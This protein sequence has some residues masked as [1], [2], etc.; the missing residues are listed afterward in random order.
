MSPYLTSITGLLLFWT[1]IG[2]G[3]NTLP[4]F[5]VEVQTP[6]CA[7]AMDGALVLTV[8]E[9]AF[10][11]T[12]RW[13]QQSN[14]Q[15]IDQGTITTP[16]VSVMTPNT[17]SAGAYVLQLIDSNGFIYEDT[18]PI[19]NPTPITITS[20]TI[21]DATCANDCNGQIDLAFTG[22]TGE[23]TINWLD[24]DN[25]HEFNRTELCGGDYFF[26][27][28]DENGCTQKG[29]IPI[30]APPPIV[31]AA[32]VQS[33][34][35]DQATNGRIQLDI[36]GGT[37]E[38]QLNW[39]DGSTSPLRENLASATYPLTVTDANDC[40]VSEVY[41]LPQGP[42]LLPNVRY[43]SGCGDGNILVSCAPIHGHAPY[44]YEWSTGSTNAALGG[45]Y[46]GNYSLSLTDANGCIA[47]TSFE[48]PYVVP[49]NVSTLPT[50]V[51]CAGAADGAINLVILG[52]TPP[53]QVNWD[54][55]M[56]GQN[57]SAL[58][59]GDY[60]YNVTAQGCGRS[61][62]LQLTEPQALQAEVV[63]TNPLGSTLSGQAIVSGGTTPYTIEW[64][65][66]GNGPVASN[67]LVNQTYAVSVTDANNC[68]FTTD[69]SAQLTS[70][71]ESSSD[72]LALF[73]NPTRGPLQLVSS[74]HWTAATWLHP[75]G[76]VLRT[77]S[78]NDL[79]FLNIS[80]W[81]AGTYFL[82]LA[83]EQQTVLRQVVKL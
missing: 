45:M 4:V 77:G 69:V 17:L 26:R 72:Q 52:G 80:T 20:F 46:A 31:V 76:R 16:G 57:I 67:L 5:A 56:T 13:E 41:E 8:T 28:F 73:P 9:G 71:Y 50:P 75:T 63:F 51:S 55:G 58:T 3:Q 82:R 38:H 65:N 22:G 14:D 42:A 2:Y 53:F 40:L 32:D 25:N 43:Q 18:F 61:G 6:S 30:L 7:Q 54:N 59:G 66:G 60:V 39:A 10:P 33:P 49:I 1:V 64:S 79:A 12:Y 36:S 74:L 81:P 47:N 29:S 70:L 19:T 44:Q 83:N 62:I 24:D 35:C 34:T 78:A 21:S 27:V 23:L 15:L 48:I 11:I 37:G 68:S